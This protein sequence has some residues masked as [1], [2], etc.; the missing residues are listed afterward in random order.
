MKYTI[1][2][3]TGVTLTPAVSQYIE[4]RINTIGR[5]IDKTDE[6]AIADVEIGKLGAHHKTGEVYRAEINV[7]LAHHGLFRSEATDFDIYNA[8]NAAKNE[9]VAQIKST[10]KKEITKT[11]KGGRDLKKMLRGW[12]PGRGK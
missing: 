6:S 2:A 5:F 4:R 12:I 7:T 11:K 1:K 10:R 8:I 3:T 9:I